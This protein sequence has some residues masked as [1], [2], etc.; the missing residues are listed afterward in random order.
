MQVGGWVGEN[1]L[2][3]MASLTSFVYH[4]TGIYLADTTVAER[5]CGWLGVFVFP[6]VAYRIPSYSK[7]TRT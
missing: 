3:L 7:D 5:V 6:L 4:F 1:P 2:T